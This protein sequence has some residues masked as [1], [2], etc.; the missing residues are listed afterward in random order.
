MRCGGRVRVGEPDAELVGSVRV[1]R[2]RSADLTHHQQRAR[3]AVVGAAS[4][5]GRS[6]ALV[7]ALHHWWC[8]HKDPQYQKVEKFE[9]VK[10]DEPD[11]TRCGPSVTAVPDDEPLI[12]TAEVAKRLGVTPRAV[13][14]WVERGELTPAVITP[15]NRFRWRWSE[16]ESQ[17]RERRQ[18]DE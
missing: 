11:K 8:V 16:V 18:R 13:T 17:L 3:G 2:P 5:D 4:F 9:T 15:G 12:T 7:L 6:P 10:N 1:D 14:R